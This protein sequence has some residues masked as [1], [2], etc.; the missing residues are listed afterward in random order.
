M[1]RRSL[2]IVVTL[3]LAAIAGVV[4]VG[5]WIDQS[6]HAAGPLHSETTLVISRG[7]SIGGI[8]EQL[9]VAGVIN[10]ALLYRVGLLLDRPPQPLK[11]G[12]YAFAPQI[13]MYDV[14]RQLRVGHTV[15]RRITVPEGLTSK[16]V[17]E[18]LR[19]EDGLK[20]TIDD[21]P[22]EGVLLPE[23]Y[24]VSLGDERPALL[25]R[26]RKAMNEA[27]A[28]AWQQ[29]AP[30]LPLNSQED[31]LILASIVEK[32]TGLAEERPRVAAVFLNRLRKGMPLQ[33]DPTVV[34]AVAGGDGR[35]DRP[36]SRADLETPSP[37]NTYKVAALPP[38]PIANPGRA[39]LFAVVQPAATDELY[40]VADGEGGHAFARTL[41]E[42]NRNV[43]R[44]RT[45]LKEQSGPD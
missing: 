1:A 38:G 43:Q 35:L 9:E 34:Y 18:L 3:I 14:T 8:A 29:R 10:N 24:H 39:A 23:T 17:V 4:G 26:M 32:E 27:L 7:T 20:G 6:Y 41:E 11:A 45:L 2:S 44:W 31:V 36:L 28:E 22:P 37:Y 33:A 40:F 12:E 13:S 25:D 30:N 5:W 15:A 16:Q 21:V 19:A 42:H